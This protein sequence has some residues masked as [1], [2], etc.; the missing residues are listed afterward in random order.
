[1]LTLIIDLDVGYNNFT[2]F[3]LSYSRVHISLDEVFSKILKKPSIVQIPHM[4]NKVDFHEMKL[5][6]FFEKK[7]QNGPLKKGH[8]PAPPILNIF[9]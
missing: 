3:L 8:F 9:W 1:M 6:F 7:I 2:E 4:K 5:F